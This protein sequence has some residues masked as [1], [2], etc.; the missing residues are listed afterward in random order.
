MIINGI[1]AADATTTTTRNAKPSAL[2]TFELV[3]SPMYSGSLATI[4]TGTYV[5]GR[6]AAENTTTNSVNFTG[7]TLVSSSPIDASRHTMMVTWNDVPSL[8]LVI[9]P[10]AHPKY[11]AML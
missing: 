7:S 5:S 6:A 4:S 11:W 3:L 10:H 8:G 9:F 2:V 1:V